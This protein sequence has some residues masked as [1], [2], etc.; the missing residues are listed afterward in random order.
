MMRL[1]HL[2]PTPTWLRWPLA[3]SGRS[4]SGAA[5]SEQESQ[6]ELEPLGQLDGL[7]GE[8]VRG[9]SFDHQR[10]VAL[11]FG[12]GLTVAQVA[13]VTHRS[14]AEV[15]MEQLLALRALQREIESRAR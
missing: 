13:R 6:E 14:K 2:P 1:P 4:A 11:R 7:M 8:A 12:R 5:G 10:L 15:R 3:S 9:L